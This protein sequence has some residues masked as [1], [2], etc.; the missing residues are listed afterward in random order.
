M[1]RYDY[2]ENILVEMNCQNLCNF[3]ERAKRE[4]D[5]FL[6]F[7]HM[8]SPIDGTLLDEASKHPLRT[9][10]CEICYVNRLRQEDVVLY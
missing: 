3:Y 6:D 9:F 7:F 1:E 8:D 5:D 4:L 2:S 10:F